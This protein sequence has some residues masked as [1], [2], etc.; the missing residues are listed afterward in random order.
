[1]SWKTGSLSQ[2][3]WMIY[4]TLMTQHN[5]LEKLA[6]IPEV[7]GTIK[8]LTFLLLLEHIGILETTIALIFIW[9]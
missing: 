4:Q 3:D 9:L 7:I 5:G 2:W 1:M 8:T 6:S